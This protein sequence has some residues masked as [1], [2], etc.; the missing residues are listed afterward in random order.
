MTIGCHS[1]SAHDGGPTPRIDLP[2]ALLLDCSLPCCFSSAQ[3]QRPFSEGYW[4]QPHS[5]GLPG[6]PDPTAWAICLILLALIACLA[7]CLLGS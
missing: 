1:S 2:E 3:G 5:R 6:S 4:E 7:F